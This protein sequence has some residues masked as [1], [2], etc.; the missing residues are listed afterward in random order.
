M[1]HRE[2]RIGKHFS[3]RVLGGKLVHSKKKKKKKDHKQENNDCE[4]EKVASFL[5]LTTSDQKLDSMKGRSK[6]VVLIHAT[7]AFIARTLRIRVRV[8]VLI[9]SCWL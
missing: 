1:Q 2:V 5:G 8:N 4:H 3:K 6:A 9:L 7:W